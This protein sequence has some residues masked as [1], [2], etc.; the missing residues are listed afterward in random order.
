MT[1]Q[2]ILSSKTFLTLS[3][4]IQLVSSMCLF[5][6]FQMSFRCK[7]FVTH[8]TQIWSWFVIMWMLGDIITIS[9]H[10]HLKWTFTCKIYS[11]QGTVLL[12]HSLQTRSMSS[13]CIILQRCHGAMPPPLVQPWKFFTGDF[14]WKGAFFAIFL[15]RV[16]K[17]NNVWWSFYIPIQYAI[18]IAMW[19]CI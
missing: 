5:M 19:D 13:R 4:W 9:F 1:L 2:V 6:A 17:F 3:T 18:K 8:C 14:I 10:L 7:P 16:A 15:A 12:H 11:R